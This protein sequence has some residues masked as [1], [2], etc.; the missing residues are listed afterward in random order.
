MNIEPLQ[1]VLAGM[2]KLSTDEAER[3]VTTLIKRRIVQVEQSGV[4]KWTHYHLIPT[5]AVL[6]G[7]VDTDKRERRQTAA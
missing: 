1:T 2:Y 6:C 7:Y 3:A 5:R 4:W